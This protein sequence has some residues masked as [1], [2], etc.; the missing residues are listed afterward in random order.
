MEQ[1]LLQTKIAYLKSCGPKKAEVLQKALGMTTYQDTLNQFPFRYID[2]SR[3]RE[4]VQ[5]EEKP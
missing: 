4:A 1:N 5:K 2:Q 3:S